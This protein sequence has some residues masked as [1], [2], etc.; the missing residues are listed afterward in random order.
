MVDSAD[1]SENEES[2]CSESSE[3]SDCG[4]LLV[5]TPGHKFA[6][7]DQEK[8][9]GFCNFYGV[10]VNTTEAYSAKDM[11]E[12]ILHFFE[13]S[14][15][16]YFL[17][18]IFHGDISDGAWTDQNGVRFSLANVL[19]VWHFSH[20]SM[21]Q[22]VHLV[23][24]IDAC[25]SGHWIDQM[26]KFYC[27]QNV[28]VQ[29]ACVNSLETLDAEESFTYYWTGV[30]QFGDAV[31]SAEDQ[32]KLDWKLRP[33]LEQ[34]QPCY[35]MPLKKVPSRVAG[36]KFLGKDSSRSNKH[37]AKMNLCSILMVKKPGVP[38]LFKT[39]Q[40]QNYYHQMQVDIWESCRSQSLEAIQSMQQRNLSALAEPRAALEHLTTMLNITDLE[41]LLCKDEWPG[42]PRAAF[43]K[44]E[45]YKRKELR[46]YDKETGAEGYSLT[47]EA[48]CLSWMLQLRL[49]YLPESEHKEQGHSSC[50]A[51]LQEM[52]SLQSFNSFDPIAQ[53]EILE[54]VAVYNGQLLEDV[55]LLSLGKLAGESLKQAR[56]R[57]HHELARING[58]LEAGVRQQQFHFKYFEYAAASLRHKAAA[59]QTGKIQRVQKKFSK[60]LTEVTLCDDF[61]KHE[62]KSQA[63]AQVLL[64]MI[65]A[66]G[67]ALERRSEHQHS[68]Q[69]TRDFEEAK[70][71]LLSTLRSMPSVGEKRRFEFWRE[72]VEKWFTHNEFEEFK[73]VTVHSTF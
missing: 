42:G 20:N 40:C 7:E 27:I 32:Q 30:N 14:F 29:A 10:D 46:R 25:H 22:H 13:D 72:E 24:L 16:I 73:Q 31:I 57:L 59:C 26:S 70:T 19:R 3:W 71:R 62:E 44:L 54:A 18:L 4:A 68:E 35:T 15:S 11:E 23:V 41:T 8:M 12:Q 67:D 60:L 17:H 50:L 64:S 69:L 21:K 34:L 58:Q 48:L 36:L 63:E 37:R 1:D 65:R 2:S 5:R 28:S 38:E 9:K 49:C 55:E 66:C 39:Y 6:H 47:L 45:T 53:H 52:L 43:P 33:C 51:L 56:M 61:T